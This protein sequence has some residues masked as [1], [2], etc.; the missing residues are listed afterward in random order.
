[1]VSQATLDPLLTIAQVQEVTGLG[2][3]SIYVKMR[4]GSFPTAVKVGVRA[5]RWRASELED[6]LG[7]RPRATGDL[8]RPEKA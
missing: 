5:V 4:D 7:S 3:S 2:R 8:V 1:M 6:W